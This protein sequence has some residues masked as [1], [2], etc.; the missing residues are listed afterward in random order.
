MDSMQT[1]PAQINNLFCLEQV[2]EKRLIRNLETQM[3]LIGK[4]SDLY[5]QAIKNFCS[6][7]PNTKNK[8]KIAVRISNHKGLMLEL[9]FRTRLFEIYFNSALRR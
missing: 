8:W 3:I 1:D 6:D 2:L 9:S 4:V 7:M 5:I